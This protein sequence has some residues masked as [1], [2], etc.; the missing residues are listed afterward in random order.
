MKRN[1]DLENQLKCVEQL[2]SINQNNA[3]ANNT[4]LDQVNYLMD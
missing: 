4:I 3:N 2:N 1:F